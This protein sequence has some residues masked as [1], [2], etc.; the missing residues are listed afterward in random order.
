MAALKQCYDGSW[1]MWLYCE[2]VA[3]LRVSKEE[4][5]RLGSQSSVDRSYSTR[6]A[7]HARRHSDFSVP[8]LM[9]DGDMDG[10]NLDIGVDADDD[11]AT[12]NFK[13]PCA[14]ASRAVNESGS[15]DCADMLS[16]PSPAS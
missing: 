12:L 4:R 1:L 9:R 13:D 14:A 16:A 5:R 15:A 10:S 2:R 7:F 3:W 6:Q 11:T 8:H